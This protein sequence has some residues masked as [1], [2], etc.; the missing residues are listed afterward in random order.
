MRDRNTKAAIPKSLRPSAG[1]LK[2]FADCRDY[3][4]M[5]PTIAPAV[6][7]HASLPFSVPPHE[8]EHERK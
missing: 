6:D 4:M 3:R 7:L 8:R 1:V 5:D 2:R